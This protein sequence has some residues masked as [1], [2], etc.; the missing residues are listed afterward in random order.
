MVSIV[1]AMSNDTY[2]PPKRPPSNVCIACLKTFGKPLRKDQPMNRQVCASC[3]KE[4]ESGAVIF[5]TDDSR[6][7]VVRPKTDEAKSRMEKYLG[8]IV[9][10]P[11]SFMN[12][13]DQKGLT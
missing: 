9:R 11:V 6:M 7:A 13:L 5:V 4:L 8:K 12:Q 10:I 3:K 1:N 2:R